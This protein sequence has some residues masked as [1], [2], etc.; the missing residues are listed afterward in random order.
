[1]KI[2]QKAKDDSPAK[3]KIE[4][5]QK[6]SKVMISPYYHWGDIIRYGT[7]CKDNCHGTAVTLL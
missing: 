5:M 4:K 6:I 1:M 3:W 7:S 2:K